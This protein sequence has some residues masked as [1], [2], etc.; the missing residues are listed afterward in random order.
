MLDWKKLDANLL[1]WNLTF[2]LQSFILDNSKFYVILG[3]LI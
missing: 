2:S 1:F 3:L